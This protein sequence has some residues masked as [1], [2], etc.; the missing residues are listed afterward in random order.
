[1]FVHPPTVQVERAYAAADVFV[2]PSISEGLSNA[3][4]EAM[5]SGLTVV[6]SRVGGTAEVLRDGETGLLFDPED[7]AGL[8]AQLLSAAAETQ[9]AARL[10]PAARRAA[11]AFSIDAVAE[12]YEELYRCAS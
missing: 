3:L 6:A 11:L 9:T 1:M 5:A 4:L 7:S 2:L 10:G 8:R 12:S